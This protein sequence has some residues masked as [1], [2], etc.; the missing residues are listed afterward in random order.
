MERLFDCRERDN[1]KAE[2]SVKESF[3]CLLCRVGKREDN[4]LVEDL[5]QDSAL[6]FLK[7]KVHPMAFCNTSQVMGK[8]WR[9]TMNRLM[10]YA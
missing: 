1:K 3:M 6:E 10:Q 2:T 4:F 7:A 8:V 5:K 9:N